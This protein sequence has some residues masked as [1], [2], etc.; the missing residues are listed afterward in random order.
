MLVGYL[1]VPK[2]EGSQTLDLQRDASIGA[3]SS[4]HCWNRRRPSSGK[5]DSDAEGS[6]NQMSWAD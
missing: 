6:R 1:R 3:A 5:C 2:A 4:R